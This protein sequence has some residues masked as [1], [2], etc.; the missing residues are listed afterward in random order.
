[1]N[2][3]SSYPQHCIRTY[4][5]L[6]LDLS[7]PHPADIC[8]EDIARGL[9]LKYRFGGHSLTALTVA[10]HSVNASWN[11]APEYAL[12]ALLHDASEAYIGDIPSPIKSLLPD[13]RAIEYKLM[14]AICEKLNVAYPMPIAIK[15]TDMH[16]LEQEWEY[17]VHACS[18]SLSPS[19]AEK[20][21]LHRYYQLTGQE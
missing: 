4:T 14:Q 5:G 12:A 9:S 8:I 7:N 17:I 3:I 18:L 21:F 20:S 6:T 15:N 13:Y 19:G 10:E 2:S 16:L 11:T 1:M